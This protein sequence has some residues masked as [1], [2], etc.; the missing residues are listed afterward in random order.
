M[1]S[2]KKTTK[3]TAAA[4]Q[5]GT[6][7]TST[8]ATAGKKKVSK[9]KTAAKPGT[10][11]PA[12]AERDATV[13]AEVAVSPAPVAGA[14]PSS[15]NGLVRLAL[16][17]SL[18]ALLIAAYAAYQFTLSGSVTAAQVS[19]LEERLVFAVQQQQGLQASF[20]QQEQ[21]RSSSSRQM[22]EQLA[23]LSGDSSARPRVRSV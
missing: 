4:A 22:G 21:G 13:K 19:A 16:I 1:S 5:A 7:T 11:A 18:L 9:K 17:A 8:G 12:T 23:T 3:K 14:E 20:D 2:K 10:S 15:G 6:E